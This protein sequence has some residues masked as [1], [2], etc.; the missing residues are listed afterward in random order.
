MELS[1]PEQVNPLF[2]YEYTPCCLID[3]HFSNVFHTI[4][5]V[6]FFPVAPSR[7]YIYP[8]GKL[9]ARYLVP[10]YS[11]IDKKSNDNSKRRTWTLEERRKR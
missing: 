6:T 11:V 9:L 4:K 1:R 10:F 8:T 3:C 5:V 7:G 2:G